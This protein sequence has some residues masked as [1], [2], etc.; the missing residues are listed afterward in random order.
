MIFITEITVTDVN[1]I[2]NLVITVIIV[3]KII[4]VINFIIIINRLNL[5]NKPLLVK[6]KFSKSKKR[7][8][9]AQRTPF[10][11]PEASKKNLEKGVGNP[12]CKIFWLKRF[13]IDRHSICHEHIY[14]WM[15]STQT[16]K[17]L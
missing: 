3:I 2:I 5:E 11:F 10:G 6:K 12:P 13:L 4:N 1:T 17:N 14:L 8:F 15:I 16:E 7:G 9:Q